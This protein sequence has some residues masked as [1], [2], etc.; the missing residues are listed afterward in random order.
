MQ[1]MEDVRE[2]SDANPPSSPGHAE[3]GEEKFRKDKINEETTTENGVVDYAQEDED[4]GV[5]EDPVLEEINIK[6]EQEERKSDEEIDEKQNENSVDL[7]VKSLENSSINKRKLENDNSN[8][9]KLKSD[10]LEEHFSARDKI[11]ND[12]VEANECNNL[13]QIQNMSDQILEEIKALNELAKEKER[14][15]NQVLHMKKLKEE[16]LIRLQ[17]KRQVL[18]INESDLGEFQSDTNNGQQSL[19]KCNQKMNMFRELRAANLEKLKQRNSLLQ[20]TYKQ[21]PMLDVQ[22]I[23]ADYRQ[24]H[25]ETVPRRGRR[26]RHT[27]QNDGKISSLNTHDSLS[28]SEM[29]NSESHPSSNGNSWN[30]RDDMKSYKDI[31]MHISK[32]SPTE[33]TEFQMQL[34]NA[35]KPPPPYPEVTVHPVTN[36]SSVAPTNSLLHGILTKG[37]LKQSSSNGNGNSKVNGGKSSFSPTLARLLTAPEKSGHAHSTPNILGGNILNPGH[38][39]ISDI[40]SGS[41]VRDEITIT[42]VGSQFDGSSNRE[43]RED[44]SEDQADRLIIDESLENSNTRTKDGDSRSDDGEEVPQCQGCNQKVAQFVCAGCGNQWY[45]SRDCQVAAWDDHSEVCSG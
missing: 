34:Q 19:L 44:E 31:L 30:R 37:P 22:S 28:L 4:N 7:S 24:R 15:W 10:E 5:I 1:I 29:E 23:I 25:P 32:L 16:L 17:R 35:S 39:S 42:P 20:T 33:K 21:K 6:Q 9:K 27:I 43:S 26:I 36:T 38:L 18:I 3:Q 2:G 11:M 41:K 13:E 40:F 14:E 8:S 12:F 45:C